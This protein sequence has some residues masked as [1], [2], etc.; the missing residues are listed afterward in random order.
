MYVLASESVV[1]SCNVCH[2]RRLCMA[3]PLL[4][5]MSLS[6]VDDMV[7]CYTQVALASRIDQQ[8]DVEGP[9]QSH[10][11]TLIGGS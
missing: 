7:L 2:A 5:T 10:A 4:F 11:Y 6:Q 1:V 8:D 3:W 9:L